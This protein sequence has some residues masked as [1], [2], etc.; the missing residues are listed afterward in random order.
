[1]ST[2]DPTLTEAETAELL[3][4]E[5]AQ[6]QDRREALTAAGFPDPIWPVPDVKRARDRRWSRAAVLHWIDRQCQPAG[7]AGT[8]EMAPEA[9]AQAQR[10]ARLQSRL[11]EPAAG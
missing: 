6:F 8:A 1:M 11:R 7:A 9:I 5:L 3:R 10:R 2:P 4:F